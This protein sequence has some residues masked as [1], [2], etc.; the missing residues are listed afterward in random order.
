MSNLPPL[1]AMPP[2]GRVSVATVAHKTM[3]HHHRSRRPRLSSSPR[4][5]TCWDTWGK[6]SWTGSGLT[7][8]REGETALPKL[9]GQAQGGHTAP[10]GRVGARDASAPW[11]K[12]RNTGQFPSTWI[13]LELDFQ[14]FFPQEFHNTQSPP[15]FCSTVIPIP[16]TGLGLKHQEQPGL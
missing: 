16:N 4:E 13:L 1:S 12:G 10:Q 15:W 5:G 9:A 14:V 8:P 2:E 7:L 3:R 6:C 11:R